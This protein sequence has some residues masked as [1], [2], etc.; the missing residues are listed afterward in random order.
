MFPLSACDFFVILALANKYKIFH[1]T[2]FTLLAINSKFALNSFI[3]ASTRSEQLVQIKYY[4]GS[5]YSY[6]L[7]NKYYDINK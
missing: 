2:H 6:Y 4:C 5:K 7:H 1:R 3:Y